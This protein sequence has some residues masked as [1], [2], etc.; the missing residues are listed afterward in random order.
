MLENK[1]IMITGASSGIGLAVAQVC[2]RL[3]AVVLMTG[4][5]DSRLSFVAQ[6]LGENAIPMSYDATNEEEVKAAF[7]H[8]KAHIGFIDGLVNNAGQMLEAPMAMTRLSALQEQLSVNTI[9]AYQH[10]QLASR[11]MIKRGGGCI[12]NLCSV[13]GEQGA[14]GQTAY[15]TAKAAVSGMTRSASKEFAPHNIRV[16]GV[17]PGFI[18][19][20]M[21]QHFDSEKRQHVI[22]TIGL[23]RA[24]TAQ[25][26][27][28]LI[29]FLLSDHASYIT[30][31][32]IG[33]DGGM[34]L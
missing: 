1:V 20:P 7:A 10:A 8:I 5:D 3:G 33:I 19:T 32:I 17:A 27:A 22:G 21:T 18:D 34:N 25:E 30:G 29:S 15:A 13:V 9:A 23:G 12:I 11:F 16:N 26:V 6:E 2:I 4:R 14:K 31:Q 28:D 24:G